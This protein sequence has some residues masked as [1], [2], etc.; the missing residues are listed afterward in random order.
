MLKLLLYINVGIQ[1]KILNISLDI[2]LCLLQK[3]YD[4]FISQI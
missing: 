4:P 3:G 1:V 2:D